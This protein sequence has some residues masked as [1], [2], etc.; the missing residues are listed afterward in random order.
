MVEEAAEGG[1][2]ERERGGAV[3]GRGL[4]RL[5]LGGYLGWVLCLF[6]AVALLWVAGRITA[7]PRAAAPVAS[8]P[9]AAGTRRGEGEAGV[10]A[11]G[12]GGPVVDASS[13]EAEE[14]VEGVGVGV[15]VGVGR[16]GVGPFSVECH[17]GKFMVMLFLKKSGLELWW[18]EVFW[19]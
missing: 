9:A 18:V 17:V 15:G 16:E 2:V 5:G 11:V 14:V 6:G 10:E 12:A 8:A 4:L 1:G 19:E 7:R 13:Y 3:V